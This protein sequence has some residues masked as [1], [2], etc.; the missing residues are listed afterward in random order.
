MIMIKISSGGGGSCDGFRFLGK[1][2]GDFSI[3][4]NIYT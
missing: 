4:V 3:M 2:H 1:N